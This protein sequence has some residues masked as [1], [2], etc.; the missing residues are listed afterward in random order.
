MRRLVQFAVSAAEPLRSYATGLLAGAMEIQD[1]AAN[2]RESNAV[3][4]RTVHPRGGFSVIVYLLSVR[5]QSINKLHN[6]LNVC[7]F[8]P[9][10]ARWRLKIGENPPFVC[11]SFVPF[12]LLITIIIWR[13]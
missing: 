5:W 2:F 4:V 3:L 7:P 6:P 1:I 8:I 10:R 11:V 13:K 9:Q 12:V